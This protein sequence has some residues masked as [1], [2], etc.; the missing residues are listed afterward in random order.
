[1]N[2]WLVLC[3]LFETIVTTYALLSKTF[4]YKM[5]MWVLNVCDKFSLLLFLSI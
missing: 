3:I 4:T 2:G 1:M 5:H